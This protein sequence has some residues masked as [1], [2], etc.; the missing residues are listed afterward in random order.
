VEFLGRQQRE[1]IAEV[2]AHLRAEPGQGPGPGPVLLRH[3][4][5][6]DPLHQIEILP[7]GTRP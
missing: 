1:A 5:V 7:H 2:E 4:L 3:P 6:E